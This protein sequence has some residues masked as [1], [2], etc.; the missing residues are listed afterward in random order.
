MAVVQFLKDN[1]IP[2]MPKEDGAIEIIDPSSIAALEKQKP[3]NDDDASVYT[4]STTSTAAK[5]NVLHR[6]LHGRHVQLLG[7]SGTIGS[8]LFVAIGKALAKGGPL[9]LLLGFIV[10]S[11]PILCITLSTAEF[12]SY[13]PITSPFVR[14]AGRCCD[15]ALE[16]MTAWN[17]WFLCCAEIPFEVV[18]VNS[19]IH[20]WRDDFSAAIPLAIQMVLYFF[21]NVFGVAIYGE[22]EFWLGLGKIVLAL[23]LIFY[24]FVTMVGGNPQHD[25][26]G[27]RYWVD[28]GV[29]NEYLTTG[30][31]GRFEGFMAC[32][33]QACF[34]FAGPEYVSSV[35]SETINP[36]KTLPSAFKQVFYRLSVFLIGGALCVGI[37]IPYNDP[38][39]LETLGASKPGAGSSPYVISMQNLG[40]SV[41]P[42]IVNVLLVSSAFSA[43][44]SYTYCS[45]RTLYGVALDGYAPKFLTAT[46]KTGIPIYC[47]LI[48]LCWALLSFLQMGDTASQV[49]NWITNLITGCQLINFT[50]LCVV[51]VSFYYGLKAQNI[52]RDTLP[53]KGWYQPWLAI[54]GGISSFTMIFVSAYTVFMPGSWD[55]QTFLFSFLLL[56]VDI[57]I[58]VG[59]KIIRRT[60]WKKSS[61]IDLVTGLREVELHEQAYYAELE[62]RHK[63]VDGHVKRNVFNRIITVIFGSE[64]S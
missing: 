26:Y 5:E 13:M 46:T 7:I 56:F 55:I 40:I 61:E 29:M 49:L 12:V 48:S 30:S 57:A 2:R 28:P 38:T 59:F 8:A 4:R 32:L 16:I 62:R 14:M 20:F 53:F 22:T 33:I 31:L 25:V 54:I 3:Q 43:G 18:T 15:E 23:G 58:F 50:I 10:W 39:L 19:I 51:Y 60:K 41:L 47:V 45:S 36:R 63:L 52:D 11:I 1:F 34:M 64:M 27:F 9:N 42:H 37:V 24:T 35:A 17:F 21:I 6:S 44:N